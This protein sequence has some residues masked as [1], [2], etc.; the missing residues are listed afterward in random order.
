MCKICVK[1]LESTIFTSNEGTL[2]GPVRNPGPVG[3]G[4]WASAVVQRT[5]PKATR[6]T[7]SSKQKSPLSRNGYSSYRG[8]SAAVHLA[9][10]GPPLR[11]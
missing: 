3:L 5:R 11:R 4:K 8:E 7:R 10:N 9:R 1:L 2:L 6:K